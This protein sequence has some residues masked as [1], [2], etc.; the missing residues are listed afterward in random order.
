MTYPRIRDPA[1][2][3]TSLL[4]SDSNDHGLAD[5]HPAN[6]GSCAVADPRCPRSKSISWA[7][8]LIRQRGKLL[9]YVKAPDAKSAIEEAIKHFDIKDPQQQRR[10]VAQRRE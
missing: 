4:L 3:A 6:F 9:G 2:V 8:T 5:D 7:I 1:A 10:L